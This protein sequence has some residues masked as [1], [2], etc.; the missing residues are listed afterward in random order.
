[1]YKKILFVCVLLAPGFLQAEVELSQEEIN[2]LLSVKIR[3]ATHMAFN[4][5]V[6][7]AV[8][9]QNGEGLP[10]EEIKKRDENWKNA[11]GAPTALIREITR[12]DVARYFQ[13][14]VENNE[15]IGEVFLTDNRGANVAA[16]PA[17]SDYWQGD[18]DKWTLSYNNGNGE[19]FIGPLEYDDSTR[20]TQVQISA[21]IISNDETIG[22]LVLGVSVDYLTARQ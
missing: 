21:P 4:P 12:N 6:I 5:S 16:Y 20:K 11:K 18:E 10:L 14:R 9:V 2:D 15:A 17:T 22:V 19:V 3:F 1:M 8:E 13:R 7:R